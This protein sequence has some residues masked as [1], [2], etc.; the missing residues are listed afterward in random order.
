[1]RFIAKAPRHILH[2][3]TAPAFVANDTF[4]VG[5]P[6]NEL[7]Q[8]MSEENPQQKRLV[9]EAENT[10]SVF[11]MTGPNQSGKSIYLKQVALIVYMAHIGSFVP[12]EEA[13]I[14]ITDKI[15]TRIAAKETV[16]NI[17]SAFAIDLKQV[18]STLRLA[19]RRSLILL[20]EFGKGT[21]SSSTRIR[22]ALT[23]L[24]LISTRWCRSVQ[25]H[26]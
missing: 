12:A 14:G 26:G 15:L 9:E 5:G 3:Q 4:L 20:D 6:T 21:E 17:H 13:T 24:M 11:L 1:M 10:P 7:S 25:R 23:L 8:A 2:D 19:S 22:P 16:S 18:L